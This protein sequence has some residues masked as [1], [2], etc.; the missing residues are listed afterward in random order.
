MGI[1][2]KQIGEVKGWKVKWIGCHNI[3]KKRKTSYVEWRESGET[4]GG[5]VK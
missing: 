3:I 2:I 5:Y 4:P 1:L